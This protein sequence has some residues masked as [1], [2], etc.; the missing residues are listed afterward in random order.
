MKAVT[1]SGAG[2]MGEAG[3]VVAVEVGDEAGLS[4]PPDG[5]DDGPEDGLPELLFGEI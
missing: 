5:A 3:G 4:V 2:A 1:T